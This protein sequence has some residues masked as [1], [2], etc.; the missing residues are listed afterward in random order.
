MSNRDG[1]DVPPDRQDRRSFDEIFARVAQSNILATIWREVYGEDYPQDASPF[2]FVTTPELIVMA[3]AMAVSKG[4]RFADIACG[5]GG[6]SLFVAR[7]TGATVVGIDSSCVAAQ[8]AT[9]T[10][11]KRSVAQQ[12][13]FIVADAAATGLRTASMDAAISVDALQLIPHRDAVLCEVS[14]ILKPGG[15]FAFSTW[16]ARQPGKGPPFPVDYRPLL[17]AA[18]LDLEACHEPSNWAQRESSV[19]AGIR[20][21]I[22]RLRAELGDTVATRLL[23]EAEKMPDACP[24]IRRVNIVARRPTRA[25]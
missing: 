9:T 23:T 14:R 20:E 12:A 10:A 4:Q 6:P 1:M 8:V 21:N 7:L 24:L 16:L 5:H 2:S 15:R 3:D 17:E 25:G 18:G 11:R 19:F 13:K 22:V